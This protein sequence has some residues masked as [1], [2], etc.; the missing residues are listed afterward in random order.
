MKNKSLSIL[1]VFLLLSANLLSGCTREIFTVDNNLK[2]LHD[3]TYPI[4]PGK[5]LKLETSS[6]D[7]N[8]SSWSKNE[9]EI[10]VFGN[11]R[12]AEKV[13]FYFDTDNNQISV[14]SKTNGWTS[15]GIRIRFEI[16]VP[17]SFNNII[18]TSGGD[19]K[20]D[21]IAGSIKLKTSG[22]D[23]DLS[24]LAGSMN[25]STSG[26]DIS[27]SKVKGDIN[28][29]TSGGDIKGVG[30]SGDAN[31]STS[32]GDILLDANNA[33]ISAKT[34][35]GDISL[36]YTGENK[37]INLSTS[38][39]SIDIKVPDDF[40]AS[41]KLSSGGGN[42]RTDFKGQNAVKISSAKF[43]ADINKGGNNLIAKTSGG[44]IR[45]IRNN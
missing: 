32:G 41:V 43:E 39:G 7:V 12:A 19:I 17:S 15:S 23:I 21:G 33:K 9:V 4:Q 13:D 16:K 6:G 11:E 38:G 18:S 1:I 5:Q 20:I 40:N 26:G 35:G 3:K 8:I 28:L 14:S 31:V 25:A 37:G 2:L 10:K 44:N 29:S 24:N 36:L 22:G 45:L 34:S 27:F 42:V 30:F